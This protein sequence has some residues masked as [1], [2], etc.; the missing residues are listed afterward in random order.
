MNLGLHCSKVMAGL[1]CERLPK[2]KYDVNCVVL[3]VRHDNGGV[4]VWMGCFTR[5]FLG[6]LIRVEGI[7]NSQR[8]IDILNALL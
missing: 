8:Y 4:M 7:I 1:V 2:E 6:P 3:T 5:D